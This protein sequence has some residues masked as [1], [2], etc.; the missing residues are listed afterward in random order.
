MFGLYDV[1]ELAGEDVVVQILNYKS[2]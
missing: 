1:S 2:K